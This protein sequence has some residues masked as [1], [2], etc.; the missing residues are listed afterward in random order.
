MN[1]KQREVHDKLAHALDTVLNVA[2][3]VARPKTLV[4]NRVVAGVSL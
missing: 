1:A 2:F 4:P 3:I